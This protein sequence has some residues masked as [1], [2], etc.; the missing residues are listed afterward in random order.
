[1]GSA[2]MRDDRRV[3][4]M[5]CVKVA[6]YTD[7]NENEVGK[8]SVTALVFTLEHLLTCLLTRTIHHHFI[9]RLREL[10]A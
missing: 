1:M 8:A 9:A 4:A 6:R 5:G 7:E 3:S 10:D 2:A